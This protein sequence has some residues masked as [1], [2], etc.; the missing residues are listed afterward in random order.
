MFKLSFLL[1]ALIAIIASV[2]A[3]KPKALR[4]LQTAA[5]V[6]VPIAVV[7]PV[8]V[9]VAAT[10]SSKGSSSKSSKRQL[11]HYNTPYES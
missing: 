8:A 7:A 3:D 2:T 9:P 5:P 6:A 10:S 1:V 4:R 11:V